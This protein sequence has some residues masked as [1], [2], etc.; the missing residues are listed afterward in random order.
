MFAYT[1]INL[2]LIRCNN[3]QF[4]FLGHFLFSFFFQRLDLKSKKKDILHEKQIQSLELKMFWGLLRN[5]WF[6]N[7]N[8][9]RN[10]KT[11]CIRNSSL[12]NRDVAF[13]KCEKEVNSKTSGPT[14]KLLPYMT[15]RKRHV[16]SQDSQ[17]SYYRLLITEFQV[18]IE[19]QF[20]KRRL[21]WALENV[22]M[23]WWL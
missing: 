16:M 21:C 23:E 18:S 14:S 20:C 9:A 11:Q 4:W 12:L 10:P 8:I 2:L 22:I 19:A 5:V 15:R 13:E 6:R 1:V 3:Q 7:D 17:C